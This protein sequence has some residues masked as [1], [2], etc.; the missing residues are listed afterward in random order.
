MDH[1][2]ELNSITSKKQ[3]NRLPSRE[4]TNPQQFSS[5][6]N[7]FRKS[8]KAFSAISKA[9]SHFAIMKSDLFQIQEMINEN[10]YLMKMYKLTSKSSQFSRKLNEIEGNSDIKV[11]TER[12]VEESSNMEKL[13]KIYNA[14]NTTELINKLAMD[15]IYHEALLKKLNEY[16]LLLHLKIN[17]EENL[18][19][20]S[21]SKFFVIK[22]VTEKLIEKLYKTDDTQNN[23]NT[24]ITDSEKNSVSKDNSKEELINKILQFNN[25][26]DLIKSNDEKNE[27]VLTHLNKIFDNYLKKIHFN[28]S[29]LLSSYSNLKNNT[30]NEKALKIEDFFA[31]KLLIEKLI[32]EKNQE[33]TK[34]STY[35]KEKD[36]ELKKLKEGIAKE[37]NKTNLE[38]TQNVKKE[39]IS[40]KLST[41]EE[42]LESLLKIIEQSKHKYNNLF[43]YL[44][45]SY[46]N[47]I[48]I[49]E[50]EQAKKLYEEV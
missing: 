4:G 42:S 25:L 26:N 33:I 50:Y 23:P 3:A 41:N 32:N 13:G 24:F 19:Q 2:K 8:G 17:G 28:Y 36:D 43:L 40:E 21:H 18:Y 22:L 45:N 1:T 9:D 5:Q 12:I 31:Q 7:F 27:T 39:K 6:D 35:L 34:M 14:T 48:K 16:F 47:S 29:E 30:I 15:A 44:D 11:L 38:K 20:E 46:I 37:K 49:T 10:S